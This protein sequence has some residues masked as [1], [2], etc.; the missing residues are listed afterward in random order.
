MFSNKLTNSLSN[1]ITTAGNGQRHGLESPPPILAPVG[2]IKTSGVL[3]PSKSL[4][5]YNT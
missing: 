4:V 2:M 3:A 1:R 5:L